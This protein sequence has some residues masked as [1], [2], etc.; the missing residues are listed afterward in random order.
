MQLL[1]KKILLV[2]DDNFIGDMFIRKLK[3]AGAICARAI[4]G[5]DGLRQLQE[6]KYDFDII[7]TDVMMA[8]MDGYEMVQK[9]KED[10]SAKNIP[11]VVLTNRTS[12]TE[13]NS[14]IKDLDTEAFFIKSDTNL[15]VLVDRLA[16]ITKNKVN[17]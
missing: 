15:S 8:G 9:I 7:I 12:L 4:S 16:E 2:E 14:K 10:E 17:N 1:D 11:I 3:A 6:A 5:R 13:E